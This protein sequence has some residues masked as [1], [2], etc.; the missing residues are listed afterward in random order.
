MNRSQSE[1]KEVYAALRECQAHESQLLGDLRYFLDQPSN[2]QSRGALLLL[3]DRLVTHLPHH[4][5]LACKGGYFA[6]VHRLRP[7]WHRQIEALH[8]ANLWCIAVLDE[9]Q[10]RIERELPSAAIEAKVNGEID[11]WIRSLAAIRE[12]ESRLLQRAFAI[13]IGGEA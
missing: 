3:I 12:D 9:L 4:L 11:N 1:L 10:E 7:S 2:E 13:D 8:G 5:E 6:E